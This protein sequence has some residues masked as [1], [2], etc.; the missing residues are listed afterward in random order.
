MEVPHRWKCDGISD[1]HIGFTH[2]KS[3]GC[4]AAVGAVNPP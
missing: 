1:I 4:D 2:I 3:I